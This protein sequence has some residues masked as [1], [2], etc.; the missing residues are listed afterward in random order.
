MKTM[1][2]AIISA[3]ALSAFAA[4]EMVETS[5]IARNW[6]M[7]RMWDKQQEVASLKGK[8]VDLV[9]LGDS[10]THFWEERNRKLWTKFCDGKT[11]L[12]LG[13]SGDRTQNVIWRIE[14]GEL[15][16]YTA[17]TVAIMIGT[18]N[19]SQDGTDPANVAEGVKKIVGMVR[20]KQPQARIVLH[21]IFPRGRAEG[22][23]RAT[24]RGRND[25]TNALLKKWAEEDGNIVWLDLT[26]KLTDA[27]G[28]VPKEIMPDELHPA[29][30]GYEIWA[31]ALKP[32]LREAGVQ[33][34]DGN[35]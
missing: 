23:K 28:W 4:G 22:T 8:A 19:N 7:Q 25:R 32:Y 9:M 21:A 1:I 17:K 5:S 12:N 30:K 14:H 11:V 18:N 13:Y 3:I 16:G 20:E 27:T 24:S 6:A 10:I 2:T 34:Q 15:D 29:A 33:S 31:E 26:E 35:K